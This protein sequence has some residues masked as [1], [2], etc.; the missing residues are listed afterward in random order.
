LGGQEGIVS[1]RARTRWLTE[2]IATMGQAH[3]D[4]IQE[5]ENAGL[6]QVGE[7]NCKKLRRKRF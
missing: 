4:P 3:E 6:N 2:R 5:N 7:E 1:G